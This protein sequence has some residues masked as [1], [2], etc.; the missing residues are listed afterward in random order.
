MQIFTIILI[1]LFFVF[2]GL[3]ISDTL[4]QGDTFGDLWANLFAGVFTALVIDRIVSRSERKMREPVELHVKRNLATIC[5]SL[6]TDL[7]P[8]M[9]WTEFHQWTEYNHYEFGWKRAIENGNY[10]EQWAE[11]FERI[12]KRRENALKEITYIKENEISLLNPNLQNE[13]LVI[14]DKLKKSE[15][16]TW[17]QDTRDI[18]KLYNIAELSESTLSASLRVMKENKL[19]DI[20]LNQSNPN[21][22]KWNFNPFK[23]DYDKKQKKSELKRL[24]VYKNESITFIQSLE[25]KIMSMR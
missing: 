10:G 12:K 16:D 19:L 5:H 18:W 21:K 15:W 1:L 9:H 20:Y 4:I 24:E 3:Y 2:G 25:A 14:S 13:V 8:I 17:F 23:T 22:K 7:A 6:V 11:Y